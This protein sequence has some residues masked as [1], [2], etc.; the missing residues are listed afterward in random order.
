MPDQAKLLLLRP[1]VY[2]YI[3]IVIAVT[4][5]Y[6]QL[7]NTEFEQ[8]PQVHAGVWKYKCVVGC[9]LDE[10]LMRSMNASGSTCVFRDKTPTPGYPN[11][12]RIVQVFMAYLFEK[13]EQNI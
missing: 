4:V 8:G 7:V 6:P 13:Y 2:L 12:C 11:R 9:M 3:I 10:R 5:L 1:L